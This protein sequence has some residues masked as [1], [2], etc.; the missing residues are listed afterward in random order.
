MTSRLIEAVFRGEVA[1]V[2]L[3]GTLIFAHA[4]WLT[5][6]IRRGT[7]RMAQGRRA[8]AMFV[9]G[10]E[11]EGA[12]ALSVLG[13]LPRRLRA[14]VVEEAA[15]GL[16]AGAGA[17]VADLARRLGLEGQA[18]RWCRS[19]RWARRALGI[20]RLA[21]WGVADVPPGL[22]SDRHPIVRARAIEWA[23]DHATPELI[24]EVLEHLD[25]PDA[26]CRWTAQDAVLRA[27]A[28]ATAPLA[29]RL[30]AE[31]GA[32]V[33][34]LLALAAR[35][36]DASFQSAALALAA[37]QRATVRAAAAVVLAGLGG[38]E[39]TATL[40]RLLADVDP[41]ARTAAAEGLGR[42]G[43]WPAASALAGL[44]TDAS[45]DVRRAAAEALVAMGAPG[46]LLL[47]RA[48]QRGT[49]DGAAVA[50]Y[51]LDVA[52]LRQASAPGVRP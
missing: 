11:E 2:L 20:H 15:S 30:Q 3:A 18:R 8:L 32:A 49:E 14:R 42:L 22:L 17:A 10:G 28:V 35:R 6:E 19:R 37:D 44:L 9:D 27:R 16:H 4:V 51:A 33:E 36:P 23:G 34:P 39:G 45:W 43:H 29:R 24:E 47:N 25:D 41:A 5:R 26:L 21:L 38:A 52:A 13:G 46:K 48:A 40:E 1:V 31:T 50:R 12:A 7:P